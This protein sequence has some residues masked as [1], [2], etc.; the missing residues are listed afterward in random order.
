MFSSV[1]HADSKR[2]LPWRPRGQQDLV[3]HRSPGKKQEKND[4]NREHLYIYIYIYGAWI[5]RWTITTTILYM[6]QGSVSEAH[7]VN[8]KL[9]NKQNPCNRTS[10][11]PRSAPHTCAYL[12]YSF[13]LKIFRLESVNETESFFP[14]QGPLQ[15]FPLQ[16]FP[17][18]GTGWTREWWNCAGFKSQPRGRRVGEVTTV[19]LIRE[20]NLCAWVSINTK[21]YLP[22]PPPLHR[23]AHSAPFFYYTCRTSTSSASDT[24]GQETLHGLALLRNLHSKYRCG[25]SISIVDIY[26]YKSLGLNVGLWISMPMMDITQ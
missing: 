22:P 1:D 5:S 7:G 4:E 18:Q 6:G 23:E 17:L 3:G 13:I 2:H 21:S 12:V 10:T 14:L 8:T 25:M 15:G 24:P 16:G 19:K 11:V 20:N 26:G 9:Q